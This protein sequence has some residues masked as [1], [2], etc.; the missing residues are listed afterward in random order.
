MELFNLL[1]KAIPLFGQTYDVSLNLIAR[2]IRWLI[3]SVGIVGVGIVLFSLVL[4]FIVLPFD[5]T[6]EQMSVLV[7]NIK[8][9][10]KEQ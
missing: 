8:E 5:V 10:L 9:I 6:K 2:L 7:D 1:D 3:S 4:K